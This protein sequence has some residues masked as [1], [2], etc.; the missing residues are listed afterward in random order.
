MNW[1]LHEV[2]SRAHC[3]GRLKIEGIAKNILLFIAIA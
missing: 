1:G 3:G 2:Q